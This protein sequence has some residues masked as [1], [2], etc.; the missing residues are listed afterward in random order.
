VTTIFRH[1]AR[2]VR[3]CPAHQYDTF[4]ACWWYLWLWC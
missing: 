3:K 2:S 4:N 1:F